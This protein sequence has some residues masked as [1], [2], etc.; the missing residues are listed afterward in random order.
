MEAIA[1]IIKSR[2]DLSD[3]IK[4]SG[5]SYAVTVEF[6]EEGGIQHFMRGF[7]TFEEAR[8]EANALTT[9]AVKE[10]PLNDKIYHIYDHNGIRHRRG[11]V[12]V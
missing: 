6:S 5:K 4:I 7:Y 9:K 8:A 12:T 11:I 3:L 2:K 1:N 10:D